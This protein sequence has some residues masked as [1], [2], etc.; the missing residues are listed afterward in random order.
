MF[1]NE[2]LLDINDNLHRFALRLTRNPA[3]AD[4]LLQATLV[5][6]LEKK[7]LFR[8]DTNLFGWTSKM[9]YNLF[10]SG[11]RARARFE[12][13]NDPA[14]VIDRASVAARQEDV[15]ELGCVEEAVRKLSPQHREILHL[16]CIQ[17]MGYGETARA[18]DLPVGTVRSRLSRARQALRDVMTPAR[19][20]AG[21]RAPPPA[22]R[23][24]AAHVR[25]HGRMRVLLS[26]HDA[27]RAS[28]K[29]GTAVP[30]KR[31]A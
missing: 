29:E 10:V 7:D 18:L 13:Q 9:M 30:L 16:V 23:P 3:D 1:A 2:D 8:S 22:P 20:T 24:E 31:V 4:D 15:C 25:H 28:Q 17:G 12:S 26:A 27:G 14:P 21:R 6:A 11:Y 5:R 19:D